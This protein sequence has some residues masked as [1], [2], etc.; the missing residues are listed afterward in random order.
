MSDRLRHTLDRLRNIMDGIRPAK[1]DTFTLKVKRLS[2]RL[3]DQ[4]FHEISQTASSLGLTPQEYFVT[5]HHYAA[6]QL[7]R[8]PIQGEWYHPD[9]PK[10]SDE[11]FDAAGDADEDN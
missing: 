9:A 7:K 1:L 5:L 6:S 4:E 2:F 11:G 10:W 8:E 3:T